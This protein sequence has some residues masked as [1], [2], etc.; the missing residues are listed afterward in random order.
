VGHRETMVEQFT[1]QAAGFAQAAAL[2]DASAMQMLL[3]AARVRSSDVVLDVACGPGIVAAAFAA[4][5]ER[6]T[7]IDLTPEMVA[8]AQLRC[9]AQGLANVSFAVGDVAQLPYA[10]RAFTIVTCRYALHHLP[11]P[12]GA[13]AQM[14]RVCAPGGRVVVADIVAS[15]DPLIA[16]RFNEAERARDPSHVRALTDDEILSSMRSA[17]LRARIAGSYR[18]AVELESVLARSAPPDPGVVRAH[19]ERAIATG[20]TLGLE[21]RRR[22]GAIHFAFPIVVAV[23]ERA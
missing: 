9:A 1:R 16:R 7:G 12:A 22:D 21:E 8:Q 18:L 13:L 11:D 3:T 20:E 15:S 19:F 10:D 2:N 4:H 14:A 17:D 5:A 6:V 23:G